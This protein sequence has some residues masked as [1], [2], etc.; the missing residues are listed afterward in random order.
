MVCTYCQNSSPRTGWKLHTIYYLMLPKTLTGSYSG[1][2]KN[3]CRYCRVNPLAPHII[4]MPSLGEIYYL[5]VAILIFV[6]IFCGRKRRLS[7]LHSNNNDI[8]ISAVN[9]NT[10]PSNIQPSSD[11]LT[12]DERVQ[13]AKEDRRL[14]ILTT[15]MHKVT[16]SDKYF[17]IIFSH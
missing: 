13:Q 17:S 3:I 1:L 4:T 2:V 5:V 10:T 16:K 12:M 6:I 9:N 7:R 14:K 15:V 11:G 8:N